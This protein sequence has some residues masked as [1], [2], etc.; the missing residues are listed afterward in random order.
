VKSLKVTLGGRSR[1]DAAWNGS[2]EVTR[3]MLRFQN[4]VLEFRQ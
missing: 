1:D 4:L 2:H 3:M